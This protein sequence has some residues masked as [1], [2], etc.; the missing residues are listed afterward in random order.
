VAGSSTQGGTQRFEPLRKP[1]SER[2]GEL[3]AASRLAIEIGPPFDKSAIAVDDGR[4]AQSGLERGD[5]QRRLAA[6]LIGQRALDIGQGEQPLADVPAPID[7]MPDSADRI[8]GSAVFNPALAGSVH[9][10]R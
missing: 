4:D 9:P 2:A 8:A 10:D 5:R 3:V 6:E 1:S 7:H